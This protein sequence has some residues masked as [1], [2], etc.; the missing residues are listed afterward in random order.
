M[1]S[2]YKYN[3]W[4]REILLKY[5]LNSQFTPRFQP[6][7]LEHNA[8]MFDYMIE[9]DAPICSLHWL[10]FIPKAMKYARYQSQSLPWLKTLARILEL[11]SWSSEK[12]RGL[13]GSPLLPMEVIKSE[14][15]RYRSGISTWRESEI[16]DRVYERWPWVDHSESAISPLAGLG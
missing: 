15:E 14:T 11:L 10:G 7:N 6:E 12:D 5:V 16:S 4:F 3:F 2:I 9:M 8:S 1:L 13:N